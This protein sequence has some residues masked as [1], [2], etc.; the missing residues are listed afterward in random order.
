MWMTRCVTR[1]FQDCGP[2]QRRFS[3]VGHST[4]TPPYLLP[5]AVIQSTQWHSSSD[6]FTVVNSVGSGWDIRGWETLLLIR[7]E[8]KCLICGVMESRI[9][10]VETNSAQVYRV[11]CSLGVSMM[12]HARVNFSQFVKL[13]LWQRQT[14]KL[15][16][17]IKVKREFS[18][19]LLL[20][21]ISRAMKIVN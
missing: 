12:F 19:D 11:R 17:F 9:I 18:F 6:R 3:G 21:Y 1:S 5:E 4:A 7:T 10:L 13:Q 16:F 2:A 8:K 15:A 14:G 20:S